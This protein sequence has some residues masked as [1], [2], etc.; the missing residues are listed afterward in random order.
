MHEVLFG[1]ILEL[2][3]EAEQS[4]L[5]EEYDEIG[6]LTKLDEDEVEE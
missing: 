2:Y 6:L 5:I 1:F 4:L 3:A